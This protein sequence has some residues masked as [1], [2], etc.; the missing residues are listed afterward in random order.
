MRDV[1]PRAPGSKG[2]TQVIQ[3]DIKCTLRCARSKQVNT[4]ACVGGGGGVQS[5]VQHFEPVVFSIPGHCSVY[6]VY[7]SWFLE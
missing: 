7:N 4:M 5:R 3:A 6:I 2:S 1:W